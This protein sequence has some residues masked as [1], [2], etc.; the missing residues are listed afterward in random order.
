MQ[1]LWYLT[2]VLCCVLCEGV[3]WSDDNVWN[4]WCIYSVKPTWRHGTASTSLAYVKAICLKV[5]SVHQNCVTGRCV[6]LHIHI[7]LQYLSPN[8][9]PVSP[10]YST[11]PPRCS[12]LYLYI[13][14]PS[15]VMLSLSLRAISKYFMVLP[16]W[17]K[18]GLLLI[19][20]VLPGVPSPN[21]PS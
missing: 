4:A 5:E 3:W 20:M 9:L 11:M 14:P 12:H 13:T 17:N 16:P 2:V 7:L 18:L 21:A 8:V 1:V 6:N 15:L 10:I 19:S